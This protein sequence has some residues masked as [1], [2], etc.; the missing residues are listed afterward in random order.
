MYEVFQASTS[1]GHQDCWPWPCNLQ[2]RPESLV[3]HKPMSFLTLSFVQSVVLCIVLFDTHRANLAILLYAN[4][5]CFLEKKIKDNGENNKT[6]IKYY[7]CT[8]IGLYW[9]HNLPCVYSWFG[10][11][12][13]PL[14][15]QLQVNSNCSNFRLRLIPCL[16]DSE[17]NSY[18]CHLVFRT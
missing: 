17:S 1:T 13:I 10:S 16:Y 6:A 15:I 14:C 11:R 2:C 3:F 12:H 4:S 5:H 9:S 8:G 18:V 7:G